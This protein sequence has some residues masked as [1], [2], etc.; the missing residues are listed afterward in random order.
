MEAILAKYKTN[1]AA[2][3]TNNIPE[4]KPDQNI[5]NKSAHSSSNKS[6]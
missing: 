2:P 5:D 3:K 6:E 1:P 4:N